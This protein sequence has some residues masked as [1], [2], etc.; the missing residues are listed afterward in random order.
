MFD[1]L[2]GTLVHSVD[3]FDLP[4]PISN[5]PLS[6]TVTLLDHAFTSLTQAKDSYFNPND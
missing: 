1:R 5:L 2:P 6:A 4:R 3:Q